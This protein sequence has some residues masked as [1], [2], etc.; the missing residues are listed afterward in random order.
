[1]NTDDRIQSF[2][3]GAAVIV[4][5]FLW[6][7]FLILYFYPDTSGERFAWAIKP[8]MTAM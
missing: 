7:A 6:L 4:I 2:T 8:H 1:M 5:P 3:R